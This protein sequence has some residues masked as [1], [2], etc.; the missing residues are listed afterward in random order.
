MFS[1]I[2]NLF[3]GGASSKVFLIV[4]GVVVTAWIAL[5]AFLWNSLEDKTT[6]LGILG[7]EVQSVIKTN[8]SL[9][10]QID[11]ILLDKKKIEGIL[12][13]RNKANMEM[14]EEANERERIILNEEDECL[15]RVIPTTIADSLL[16]KD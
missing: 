9:N 15:D 12:A 4:G 1:W 13:E 3:I 11:T 16:S 6:E 14:L 7:V 2:T 8:E 10:T 5:T